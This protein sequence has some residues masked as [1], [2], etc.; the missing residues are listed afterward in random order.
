MDVVRTDAGLISGTKTGELGNE[1]S[2]YRG[3]PYAAPPIGEFRW[4]PPQP[5]TPWKGTRECVN[6]STQA[7]QY[8]DV[9]L[10]EKFREVPSSEDCLYLNVHIPAEKATDSLPVMV[11]LHGG[12]LRYGNGNW[13]LQNSPGLPQ[14]GV[15][16]VTVNSRLGEMGLFA[17]N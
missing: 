12:G 3:I 2:T 4:R 7:A 16:L 8:P 14:H 10:S 15:V 17:H 5:V 13:I 6:Y 11:W 9:N 1:V